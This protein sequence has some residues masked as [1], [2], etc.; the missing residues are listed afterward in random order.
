MK[1]FDKKMVG[2]G[3]VISGFKH[4][5]KINKMM[6]SSHTEIPPFNISICDSGTVQSRPS[7]N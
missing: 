1:S 6:S 7:T 3:R 5:E 2:F 4:L